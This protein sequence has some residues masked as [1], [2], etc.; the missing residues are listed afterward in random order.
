MLPL[1][2]RRGRPSLHRLVALVALCLG[3]GAAALADFVINGTYSL[4]ASGYDYHLSVTNNGADDILLV[5]L[6]QTGVLTT[7]S[8]PTAPAG[9]RIGNSSDGTTGFVD[10]LP[11]PGSTSTFAAGT[12]VGSFGF[13]SSTLLATAPEVSALDVNGG[14]PNGTVNLVQVN[15]P[16]PD[17]LALAALG[18]L[19]GAGLLLRQRR[20]LCTLIRP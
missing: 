1:S 18:L 6:F 11:S 2:R 8:S 17:S 19:A 14:S 20:L 9:F 7:V 5:S 4:I 15:A 16:E 10:F 12:T 13:A 3:I